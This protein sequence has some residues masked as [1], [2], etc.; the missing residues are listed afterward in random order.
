[1]KLSIFITVSILFFTITASSS[2]SFAASSGAVSLG[3]RCKASHECARNLGCRKS[4]LGDFFVCKIT[5]PTTSGCAA[6]LG[7][8]MCADG[9]VCEDNRCLPT[10]G[11]EDLEDGKFVVPFEPPKENPVFDLPD[12]IG[13]IRAYA[14]ISTARKIFN[15]ILATALLIGFTAIVKGFLT[16]TTATGFIPQARRGFALL[17]IGSAITI[18]SIVMWF[19]IS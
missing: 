10:Y 16:Y 19:V 7:E 18:G 2:S 17:G 3:G 5:V 6:D 1:M 4:N 12:D 15:A 14:T 8:N 13:P 11:L 9:L